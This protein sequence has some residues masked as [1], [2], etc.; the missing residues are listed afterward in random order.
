MLPRTAHAPCVGSEAE[1]AV[2]DSFGSIIRAGERRMCGV[3]P[4]IRREPLSYSSKHRLQVAFLFRRRF[5][6]L[7]HDTVQKGLDLGMRRT[8]VVF[9]RGSLCCGPSLLR[10][11][12]TCTELPDGIAVLHD[13]V[14]GSCMD[15][16]RLPRW[17][18]SPT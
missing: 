17:M 18:R 7:A 13:D 8:G 16:W 6:R 14:I 10:S 1:Q 15:G 5:L 11:L 3:I 4:I 12:N 2:T 9:P